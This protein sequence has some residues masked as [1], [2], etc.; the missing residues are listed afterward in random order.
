MG[1]A[2]DTYGREKMCV[3]S[4]GGKRRHLEDL[5][6]DGKVVLKYLKKSVGGGEGGLDWS[7][8]E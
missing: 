7:G 4:F 2:W 3:Q 5:G 8:S 6:I 1:G